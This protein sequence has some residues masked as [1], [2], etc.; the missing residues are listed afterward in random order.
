M[1]QARNIGGDVIMYKCRIICLVV[2]FL[3]LVGIFAS[4]TRE[5]NET[6]KNDILLK[7]TNYDN[8]ETTMNNVDSN[9]D[10]FEIS[11][12]FTWTDFENYAK[13]AGIDINL[14]EYFSTYFFGTDTRNFEKSNGK[15]GD[16]EYTLFENNKVFLTT[17]IGNEASIT[18]P[19][20]IDGYEVIGIQC[21][22]QKGDFLP[23]T[24]LKKV[25]LQNG[26]RYIGDDVF[27]NCISLEEIKLPDSLLCI[28][29][30]AFL[31]CR[32]LE[33][34]NLPDGLICI[35]DSTFMECTSLKEIVIP[36]SVTYLGCYAFFGCTSLKTVRLSEKITQ[37]Y[38][39]TFGKCISLASINIPKNLKSIYEADFQNTQIDT[40]IFLKNN[41]AIK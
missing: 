23:N 35:D 21:R 8:E 40:D 39:D 36:N 27:E 3:F 25:T 38:G 20:K 22:F 10:C 14:C 24:Y 2:G 33:S 34:L 7:V 12:L 31:G 29:N 9:I 13:K 30:G 28:D 37:L 18:I 11:D 6:Q 5:F 16:W 19:S 17:Y 1:S 26:I 32:S 41:V 4:C 15:N